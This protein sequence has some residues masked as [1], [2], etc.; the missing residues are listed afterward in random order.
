VKAFF[1]TGTVF[2][3]SWVALTGFAQQLPASGGQPATDSL[4][5]SAENSRQI[6][7]DVVVTD[8][9]GKPVPG[10]QQQN[11]T[12]FDDKHPASLLAFHAYSAAAIPAG[13][14][15]ASTEIVFILDEANASYDK[16]IY[17]RQGIE[18]YLK[19]NNGKLTHPVSVGLFTDKGLQLQTQPTVDGNALAAALEQ[20]GQTYRAIDRGAVGGDFERL[21]LSLDALNTLMTQEQ[22]KPG[23]KMVI[24]VSPGWPLI[25]GPRETLTVKQE[26][27]VFGT[28]VRLSAA[29]RQAR[30]T[31]YSVDSLGA[32]GTGERSVFYQ[33]FTKA[34]TKPDDAS[35]GDLGLQ[36]LVSQT[37]GRAIFGNDPIANSINHC[38]ADLSAFYT[39][40]IE[41]APA[42]R[43]NQFH[44]LEVKV[45]QPGLK[46]RTRDG[47][48][49]QP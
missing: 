37:G 38:I 36:V 25:S 11:F 49:T 42:D 28:V 13:Q 31:L 17:A 21:Q 7:L 33:N 27:Q 26:Q 39:L 2:L 43:P 48:Y 19:Q 18:N 3:F 6:L 16:V 35:F 41:A 47:Y 5:S 4:V 20:Q 24:W 23:R 46:V 29:L 9:S 34:L 30:I 14:V 12:V 1:H 44:E 10:L 45:A 22:P 15:D 32:A 40:M 8:K